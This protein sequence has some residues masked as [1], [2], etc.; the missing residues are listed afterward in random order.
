MLVHKHIVLQKS[1]ESNT[2]VGQCKHCLDRQNQLNNT[3]FTCALHPTLPHT[4]FS[5][6]F[7]FIYVILYCWEFQRFL[8]FLFQSMSEWDGMTSHSAR[9]MD[10]KTWIQK[11]SN[12][13]Q[14]TALED[15]KPWASFAK[16]HSRSNRA[17]RRWMKVCG[18]GRG[19]GGGKLQ[20]VWDFATPFE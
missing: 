16:L 15:A 14:G 11:R 5:V 17:V 3:K 6:C 4:F 19:E 13:W 10:P 18:R 2:F 9:C 12:V 8:L 20:E 1:K 7:Q